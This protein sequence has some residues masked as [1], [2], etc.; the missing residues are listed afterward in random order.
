MN[1]MNRWARSTTT[2]KL[3]GFLPWVLCSVFLATSGA[4]LWESPPVPVSAGAD[5]EAC[6]RPELVRRALGAAETYLISLG[7][8]PAN[9]QQILQLARQDTAAGACQGAV[10]QWAAYCGETSERP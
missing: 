8:R 6:E 10:E 7:N 2:I 3:P 9:V 1:R 5:L 4:M